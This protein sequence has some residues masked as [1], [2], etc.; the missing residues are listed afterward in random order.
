MIPDN[1]DTDAFEGYLA[2]MEVQLQ[3]IIDELRIVGQHMAEMKICVRNID[4][5]VDNIEDEVDYL[6]SNK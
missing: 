2:R 3:Q 6:T 1:V 5:G 4:A